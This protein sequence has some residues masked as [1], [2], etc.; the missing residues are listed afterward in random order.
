MMS[1]TVFNIFLLIVT[2]S[3][4]SFSSVASLKAL[5]GAERDIPVMINGYV[6]KEL[7]RL[8]YLKK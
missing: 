3:A 7:E 8:D 5:I 2:V 1:W 6:E 4:D